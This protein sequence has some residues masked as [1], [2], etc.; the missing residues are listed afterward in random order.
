MTPLY[1]IDPDIIKALRSLPVKEALSRFDKR[2][3]VIVLPSE[4]KK[5][6]GSYLRSGEAYYFDK[7][8]RTMSRIEFL[9]FITSLT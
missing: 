5:V 2:Y 8:C 9:M 1:E 6:R 4:I 7:Q 3:A